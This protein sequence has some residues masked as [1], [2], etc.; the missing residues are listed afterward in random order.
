MIP[1]LFGMLGGS[2]SFYIENPG[3]SAPEIFVGLAKPDFCYLN[4]ETSRVDIAFCIC[5]RLQLS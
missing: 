1:H 3:I 2:M 4:I 5:F